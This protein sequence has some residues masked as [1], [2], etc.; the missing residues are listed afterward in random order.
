[1]AGFL[2]LAPGQVI[3]WG[4]LYYAIAFLVA[5]MAQETGWRQQEIFTAFSAGL[6]VAAFAAVPT[7]RM[8][9]R[10]GGR[11]VMSM[12]SLLAALALLIIAS[13]QSLVVFTAGWLLAGLAMTL[14]QYEAAFAA[15]RALAPGNFR[16]ALGW[17]TIAGGLASTVFWPLT[18]WLSDALGWRQTVLLFAGLHLPCALLHASLPRGSRNDMPLLGRERAK[19]SDLGRHTSRVPYLLALAFA[20]TAI[21][22]ATVS[23]HAGAL[24]KAMHISPAVGVSFL[25]LVGFMQVAGRLL[26]LLL[27][28]KM[29]AATT[30]VMALGLL[31]AGLVLLRLAEHH[32]WLLLL[33]FVLA[34]GMANGIMTVVRGSAPAELLPDHDY[35]ASLGAISAPALLARALAPA[36]A[37]WLMDIWGARTAVEALVVTAGIGFTAFVV[38]ATDARRRRG[39]RGAWRGEKCRAQ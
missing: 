25:A 30:G 18:H 2:L 38:A 20:A 1:M 9:S 27:A 4:T 8:L 28:G 39:I 13:S 16:R 35:A 34:Y 33:G 17:L 32:P 22:T 37:A 10:F 7:G 5:P 11:R 29:S 14:T 3:S 26:D 12:G 23:A 36:V 31:C 19:R 6:L 24:L 15:L 21:V